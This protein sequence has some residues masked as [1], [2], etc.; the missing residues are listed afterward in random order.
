[1]DMLRRVA[2]KTW[3][4]FEDFAAEGDN[5]L[6]PDNFQ[7]DPPKIQ[8]EAFFFGQENRLLPG[9]VHR[10]D[11]VSACQTLNVFFHS[12]DFDSQKIRGL[13]GAVYDILPNG[14]G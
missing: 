11:I 9:P 1:M 2:R 8:A 10:T 14:M 12:F 7:L 5:Y 6:P 13:R 4:F 3:R